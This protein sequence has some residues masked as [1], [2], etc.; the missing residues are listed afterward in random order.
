MV[1]GGADDPHVMTLFDITDVSIVRHCHHRPRRRSSSSLGALPGVGCL[2]L[3]TYIFRARYQGW[4]DTEKI[5]V[6]DKERF[7]AT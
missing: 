3:E 4:N 7:A 1:E 6:S 2:V 5:S